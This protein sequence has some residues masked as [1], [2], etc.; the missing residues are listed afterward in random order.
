[1]SAEEI[2]AKKYIDTV[3]PPSPEPVPTAK[4]QRS[5][6]EWERDSIELA[7]LKHAKSVIRKQEF[8]PYFDTEEGMQSLVKIIFVICHAKNMTRFSI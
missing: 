7:E 2:L 6:A 8:P 1:M 3:T 5:E 4:P